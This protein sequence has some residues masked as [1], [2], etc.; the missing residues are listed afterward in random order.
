MESYSSTTVTQDSD[1]WMDVG[2][3]EVDTLS[4]Y[5]KPAITEGATAGAQKGSNL[6]LMKWSN[7]SERLSIQPRFPVLHSLS[8]HLI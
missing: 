1:R 7:G 5:W 2:S 8:H 4:Q 3:Q 6:L